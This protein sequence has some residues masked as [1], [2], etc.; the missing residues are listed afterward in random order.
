MRKIYLSII[1]LLFAA[2]LSSQTVL[3]YDS[4]GLVADHVN[5]MK[6]T[7]Y[8]EPGDEGNNVVW[9][10]RTLELVKEFT[11]K[12]DNPSFT[13]GANIFTESNSVLEEFGNLFFFNVSKDAIEQH[14][15]MSGRG[16]VNIVYD[17]P[18]VK[19]RYPFTYGSSFAGSFDGRYNS[20]DRQLGTLTGS[21]AVKGDGMGVLMLPGNYVYE[22]ALRVKEVKSYTQTINNRSYDIE[23]VTYRWYVNEHRFPILVLIESTHNYE[24]GRTH[25]STQAAYNPIVFTSDSNPLDMETVVQDLSLKA[26]P[27]PYHN[28]VN[29]R[30]DLRNESKVNLSVYDLNGRLVKVLVDGTEA[31][32]ERMYKFSAKEMGL[33]AGA[34]IVKLNVNGEKASQRILELQ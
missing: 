4:H 26:Y 9:D 8:V 33:S 12:L 16:T 2:S 15:Y 30:F 28:E 31:A 27:N 7:E 34:Y 6:I 18:F 17:Q 10:F 21:Y 5:D 32:G 25:T 1:C 24:S 22:N 20:A 23:T 11:G 14:G 29:L 13:K 19:M 3:R